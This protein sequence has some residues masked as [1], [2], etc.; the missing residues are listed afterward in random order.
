MKK[1]NKVLLLVLAFCFLC[2]GK[3]VRAAESYVVVLDPGHGGEDSGCSYYWDGVRFNE[4]AIN[5]KIAKYCE[6]Y[7]KAHAPNLKV[8]MTRKTDVYV[9][10]EERNYIAEELKADFLVSFHIND[11]GSA[12]PASGCMVLVSKGQ[13]RPYIAAK[14]AA[15]SKYVLENLAGLG[16][17]PFVGSENGLYFRLSDNGSKYPNGA[18]SDYYSIVCMSVEMDFPG[19][20]IEHAFL[21][22]YSETMRHLNTNAKLKALGEADAKAIISYFGSEFAEPDYGRDPW[23]YSG[24]VEKKGKFY[25]RGADGEFL[26]SQWLELGGK[27]FYLRASGARATGFLTIGKKPYYFDPNGV[28][29]KGKITVNGKRYFCNSKG[30]LRFGWFHTAADNFYYMYPKGTPKQG[31]AL[32]NGS[33]IIGKKVYTFDSKGMC[34]N[35]HFA[36]KATAAQKKKLETVA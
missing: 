2:A 9:G 18:I 24:W 3:R 15:F 19:V 5:L 31:Q 4:S 20:I 34:T 28:A 25:Y 1:L 8:H 21:S 6:K 32:A 16:I 22:N 10:V 12:G 29:G 23:E 14:E 36:K 35:Y 13:Y 17:Q 7:L 33:Y 11:A 26:K 30:A 27:R